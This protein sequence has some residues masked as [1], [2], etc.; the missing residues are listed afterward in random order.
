MFFHSEL[1]NQSFQLAPKRALTQYPI[2]QRGGLF[3]YARDGADGVLQ[4]FLLRQ[5]GDGEQ[6]DWFARSN[7]PWPEIE[8]RGLDADVQFADL[9]RVT[10][11]SANQ[12]H[13][14][15]A[16]AQKPVTLRKKLP[17]AITAMLPR[18]NSRYAIYIT[19]CLLMASMFGLMKKVCFQAKIGK[20]RFPK[21]LELPI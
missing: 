20:K 10:A 11:E 7:C 13:Q 9:G 19:G 21:I 15:L 6:A 3:L 18:I 12:V 17:V 14:V 4:P 2:F 16:D 5:S 1:A 8:V